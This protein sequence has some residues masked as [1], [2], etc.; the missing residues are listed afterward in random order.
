MNN[1]IKLPDNDIAMILPTKEYNLLCHPLI[2]IETHLTADDN[3]NIRSTPDL[4]II[5]D[6]EGAAAAIMPNLRAGIYTVSV[7]QNRRKNTLCLCR[8][9]SCANMPTNMIL[10]WPNII[11]MLACRQKTQPTVQHFK[12]S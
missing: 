6:T 7:M 2:E 8:N 9:H 5:N 1:E 3:G 11:K 10:T 12:V 4:N